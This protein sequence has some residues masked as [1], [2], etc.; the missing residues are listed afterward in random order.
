MDQR[1]L[2]SS[3]LDT[4]T[5]LALLLLGSPCFLLTYTVCSMLQWI[6]ITQSVVL[7]GEHNLHADCYRNSVRIRHFKS[8]GSK[9]VAWIIKQGKSLFKCAGFGLWR[10]IVFLDD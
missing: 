5:K 1:I 3:D 4:M 8:E 7:S 9:Q 10:L 2:H 6:V